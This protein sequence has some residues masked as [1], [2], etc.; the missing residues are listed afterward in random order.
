MTAPWEA[1]RGDS[2]P[3]ARF[4]TARVN[5]MS[6][7][8]SARLRAQLL[9]AAASVALIASMTACAPEGDPGSGPSSSDSPTQTA[10]PTETSGGT[11]SDDPSASPSPSATA[12]TEIPSDC[13]A[14]L[15]DDV[16]AQLEGTPLNDDAFGP[17]GYVAGESL[18]CIWADPAADTSGLRTTITYVSRGAALDMLNDLADN[19]GYTCYTPDHGTR[20]EKTWENPNYPVT[21]GQTLFWR[22]GILIDTTY[23]NLAPEGYTTSI[24]EHIWG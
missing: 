17:S 1:C 3:I 7:P 10:S 22:D 2:T 16:L 19:E 9:A 12:S 6:R 21:D 5:A 4:A 13:R 14:I 24:V 20:C 18:T 8:R 23:S 11:P 15:S